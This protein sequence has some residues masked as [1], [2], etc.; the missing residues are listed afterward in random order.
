MEE[1]Q[2]LSMKSWAED[3]RPRERLLQK[4]AGEL[5]LNELFAILLRSGVGGESALELARRILADNRNDL[6]ELAK[7]SVRELVNKYKGVGV[8]KATSIVAAM[9]IGRRRKPEEIEDR[10]IIRSSKDAYLYIR[11]FIADLEHEEFWVI[12]L[13]H[14][15][16]ILGGECISSGGMD[17]TVIDV[18]ILFRNALNMKAS[19][20]IV[21]HNHPGGSLSPSPQDEMMTKKIYDGGRLLDIKL[22]DH[23]I[24]G[25]A[26][27]YS[28]VDEGL[29][30][31]G[32]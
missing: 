29:L 3:E 4:G 27:Y 24:V 5:S 8:A 25:G 16:R 26:G 1:Q 30:V 31:V 18:R 17:S 15:N 10:A 12:Y 21:A 11:S 7:R 19:N 32:M 13:T 9:E 14:G 22:Y 6:N 28:F 23:I 2:Y 20:I